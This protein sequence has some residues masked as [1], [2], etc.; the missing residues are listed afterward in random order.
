MDAGVVNFPLLALR[1]QAAHTLW[2]QWRL[3]YTRAKR[4]QGIL[5]SIGKCCRGGNGAAF[6]HALDAEGVT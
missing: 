4:P 1:N 2:T 5:H 6:A 3:T